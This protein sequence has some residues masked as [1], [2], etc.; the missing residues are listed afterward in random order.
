MVQVQRVCGCCEHI[1][2]I[3]ECTLVQTMINTGFE[4][5]YKNSFLYAEEE[6]N[7]AKHL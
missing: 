4:R 1:L 7:R 6:W 5:V 3:I 2:N